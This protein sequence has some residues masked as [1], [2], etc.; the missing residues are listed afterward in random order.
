[1]AIEETALIVGIVG[2]VGAVL[3]A[4]IPYFITKRQELRDKL[5]ETKMVRHD[6]LLKALSAFFE[7]P[8]K[9]TGYQLVEAYNRS[10]SYVAT[11]VL[12]ASNEFL[13]S[14]DAESIANAMPLINS[15][16]EHENVKDRLERNKPKALE[17]LKAIRKDINPK[18]PD[19]NFDLYLGR[20]V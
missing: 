13:K 1:M 19:Y 6:D 20:Q 8:N 12:K 16:G 3:A 14:M 2:A 17:I 5:K 18:E 15:S 7:N 4:T 10:T 9:D 11:N